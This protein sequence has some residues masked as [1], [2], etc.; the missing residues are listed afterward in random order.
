MKFSVTRT[1]LEGVL[2]IE[3]EFFP[4]GRGFFLETWNARDFAAAGLEMA[5]VQDSHSRSE[6]GVLRGLH[7]QD[8]S[9]PL[10]KLVRCTV[11]TMFDVAVDLRIGSPTFGL[12]YGVELSAENKRQVYVPVGFAHGFQAVSELVEVQYRQ[13]GYYT[14]SAEGSV[15]WDDPQIGIRWPIGTPTL[16]ERDRKGMTLEEY[17]RNPVFTAAPLRR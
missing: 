11:G 13:T 1:P 3:P 14:P 7:Y 15:A 2:L 5:F 17:R 12:Y 9:A 10:G 16:S 6:R 8:T 4:D